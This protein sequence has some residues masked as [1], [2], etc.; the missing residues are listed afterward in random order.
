[1]PTPDQNQPHPSQ[2]E[3]PA[4]PLPTETPE[5][6]PPQTAP[7]TSAP[8]EAPYDPSEFE[9]QAHAKY[10][11]TIL[12]AVGKRL[13]VLISTT[14]QQ[15][16]HGDYAIWLPLYALDRGLADLTFTHDAKG[17]PLDVRTVLENDAKIH[18]LAAVALE[19]Y[20]SRLRTRVAVAT[21]RLRDAETAGTAPANT[22]LPVV[23][24][25]PRDQTL[26]YDD[27]LEQIAELMEPPA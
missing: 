4:A 5:L 1:M 2:L 8:T 6:A 22:P 16:G 19:R 21:G 13:D 24:W 9:K 7:A 15:T 18:M 20:A 11:E 27:A 3:P 12:P 14:V 17:Q 23:E 26:C 25:G 10:L